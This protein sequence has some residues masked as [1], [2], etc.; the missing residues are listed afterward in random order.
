MDSETVLRAR[1]TNT[2]GALPR[3]QKVRRLWEI[4]QPLLGL[5]GQLIADQLVAQTQGGDEEDETRR[6]CA[7]AL[8]EIAHDKAT[9]F[10]VE[11]NLPVGS[12]AK[13]HGKA[14]AKQLLAPLTLELFGDL[15]QRLELMMGEEGAPA[16]SRCAC[17]RGWCGPL[18]A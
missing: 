1:R 3:W 13:L 10:P 6:R 16:D 17:S 7:A 8:S 14:D 12:K 2:A 9:I 5:Y 18:R 4:V 11:L 15:V